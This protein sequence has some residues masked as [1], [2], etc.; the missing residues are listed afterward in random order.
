[1]K[2]LKIA[3]LKKYIKPTLKYLFNFLIFSYN[4][5]YMISKYLNWLIIQNEKNIKMEKNH[6]P[7]AIEKKMIGVRDINI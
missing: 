4:L 6:V 2:E 3:L 7:E 5:I 1:M